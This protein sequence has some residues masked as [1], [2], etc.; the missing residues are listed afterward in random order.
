M[1]QFLGLKTYLIELYFAT[2]LQEGCITGKTIRTAEEEHPHD[3]LDV[4]ATM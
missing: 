1:N 2:P 3:A 4:L